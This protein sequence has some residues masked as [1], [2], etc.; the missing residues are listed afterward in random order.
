[1]AKKDSFI[2]D[3]VTITNQLA[4]YYTDRSDEL[5]KSYF[6]NGYNAGGANEITDADV[7]ALYA[8]MT[9]ADFT[10]A[11]SLMEQMNNLMENRAVTQA[12]WQA[13]VNAVRISGLV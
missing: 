5:H 11:I 1:M 3:V 7:Q 9:A 4:K 8:D 2:T 12:D 13:S 6:D 10:Q